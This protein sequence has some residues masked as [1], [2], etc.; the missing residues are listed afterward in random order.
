MKIENINTLIENKRTAW[1]NLYD[2]RKWRAD[3]DDVEIKSHQAYFT[4]TRTDNSDWVPQDIQDKI[5]EVKEYFK[6]YFNDVDDNIEKLESEYNRILEE[7]KT[8]CKDY[9]HCFI[10]NITLYKWRV[11]TEKYNKDYCIWFESKNKKA[12]KKELSETLESLKNKIEELKSSDKID[13]YYLRPCSIESYESIKTFKTAKLT[14][15]NMLS[16]LDEIKNNK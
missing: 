5:S 10:I 2:A 7:E 6:N 9:K 16:I 11:T 3:H 8:A 12:Y 4:I 14:V 13:S 1:S 15:D